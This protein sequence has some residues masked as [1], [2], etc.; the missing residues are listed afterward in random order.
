MADGLLPARGFGN[1]G[2]LD[3]P[4]PGV[5]PLHAAL[6]YDE[7]LLHALPAGVQR[8]SPSSLVISPMRATW[9]LLRGQRQQPNSY[10]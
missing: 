8:V 2:D 10:S 5:H 9:A 3:D 6:V 4:G 7:Q 1:S